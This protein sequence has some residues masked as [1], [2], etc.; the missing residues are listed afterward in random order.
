MLA[1]IASNERQDWPLRPACTTAGFG[2]ATPRAVWRLTAM[3]SDI[4]SIA[5]PELSAQINPFG[6][7]LWRLQDAA[8]RDLLWDGDPA[9]WTGRAPLLFP[10]IGRLP[11]DRFEHEG[12]VYELPKHGFARRRAFE[13]L[14]Q[15][16]T[17]AS[18]R[19]TA[20]VETMAAY[21]FDFI[22][23]VLFEVCG[24]KLSMTARVAN[25][26]SAPMPGTFGFH[27]AFRWPLPEAGA[28][29]DHAIEFARDEPAALRRLGADGLLARTPFPSPIEGRRL[30]LRDE[31]FVDDALV[32]E[33]GA[34]HSL[35][36]GG[37]QGPSLTISWK[38][39]PHLGVW[40]KP[41]APYICIEPWHDLPA[42]TGAPSVLTD[43]PALFTLA[44]GAETEFSMSVGVT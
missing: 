11:G 37:S 21:P 24:P 28:R 1:R 42:E 8:G 13:V 5:S 43:R 19:L 31:H 22:L 2:L 39:L 40:T 14:R 29:A 38:G 41:G 3:A 15:E 44:P 16:P 7:E 9:W 32:F 30:P 25:H 20:D 34:N 36:Y 23:E 33:H 18:F 12:R 17:L 10:I 4:V 26:G 35:R 27:P 6:A